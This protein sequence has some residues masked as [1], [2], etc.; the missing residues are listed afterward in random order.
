MS[1]D[2]DRLR[3][4]FDLIEQRIEERWHIPV[5]IRDVPNPFTGDLD[6]SE[7]HIEFDLD[8]EDSL[9]ILL[10]LF[11]H[12]VQWNVSEEAR[13]IAFLK[14]VTWTEPELAQVAI[15]EL[16]ACRYSLQL[17]HEAGIRDLDHWVSDFAACDAEYLLHFYRTGEKL[18]FRSFWRAGAP[19]LSPLAI[20]AFRPTKWIGRF[21]GTVV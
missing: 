4:V 1:P 14:P 17:L 2:P 12:T 13:R 21:D 20:P 6:G 5:S 19:L 9:F 8:V 15:Y 7:I 3:E 10:H 18:P 16:E 11:G